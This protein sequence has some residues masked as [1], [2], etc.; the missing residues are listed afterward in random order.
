MSRKK[1]VRKGKRLRSADPDDTARFL[2][3]LE[4]QLKR[5]GTPASSRTITRSDLPRT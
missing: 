5:D 2:A 1:Q 3:R 4:H